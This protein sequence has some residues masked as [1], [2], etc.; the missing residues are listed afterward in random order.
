MSEDAFATYHALLG[1]GV[2]RELARGILPVSTYTVLVWKQDLRNLIC[3]L[4]N[5]DLTASW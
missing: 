3:A 5:L 2:S 4:Y 1:D